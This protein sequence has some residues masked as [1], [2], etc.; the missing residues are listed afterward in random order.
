[1]REHHCHMVVVDLRLIDDR[2]ELDETGHPVV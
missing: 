2:D 1:L